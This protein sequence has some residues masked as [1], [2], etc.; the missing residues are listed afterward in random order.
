MLRILIFTKFLFLNRIYRTFAQTG[1][2]SKYIKVR[3]C[4]MNKNGSEDI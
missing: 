4:R 2:E 3:F 1:H